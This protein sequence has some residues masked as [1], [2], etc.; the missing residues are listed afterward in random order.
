[1]FPEMVEAILQMSEY[2]PA[3]SPLVYDP[4]H[5]LGWKTKRGWDIYFGMDVSDVEQKLIV[6]KAVVQQLK[7]DGI[8]PAMISVEYIHA[9]YYRLEP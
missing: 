6:Y 9:P 8:N 1:M 5:G 4:K 7:K 3:G 2:A